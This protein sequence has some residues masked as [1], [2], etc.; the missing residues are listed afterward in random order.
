MSFIESYE[1]SCVS[2][3]FVSDD[4]IKEWLIFL[5]YAIHSEGNTNSQLQIIEV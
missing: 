2:I 3:I 1:L 4:G 5:S